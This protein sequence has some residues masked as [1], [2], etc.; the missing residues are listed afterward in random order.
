MDN[1]KKVIAITLCLVLAVGSFG[2]A[3][4]NT[5]KSVDYEGHWAQTTIQKWVDESKISGYPD[6]SF[7]PDASI[8]RAE[9]VKMVNGIIDYD[10][11]GNL[12]FS[13]VKTGDWYYDVISI[14]QEI[15][16]ITGYSETQ[17]GPNDNITREQAA[18]I[19]SRI[20]YLGENAEAAVKFGDNSNIST[21][22]LGSVGAASEVGFIK[23]YDNG[24]F[25]PLN[26]LTRAEAV[27]MLDNVL[28]NSKNQVIYKAGTELSNYVV[29]GDLIIAK[30]VGEGD[31][32]LNNVEVKG[33][34]YVYGGGENSLYFNN[35]KVARVVV[36]KDKVRLVFD[37]GSNIADIIVNSEAKL[38]NE[39]GETVGNVTINE[40]GTV[41][42]KGNFDD[43]TIN[44]GSTANLVGTFNNVLI[45]TEKKV[46]VEGTFKNVEVVAK[47][48]FVMKD[49]KITTLK[50]D[51]AVSVSG[52]GTIATLNA[53]VDGITYDSTVKVTKTV[54]APEVTKEPEKIT[55][56]ST[57]GS[58]SGSGSGSDPTY[59]LVIGVSYEP[60]TPALDSSFTPVNAYSS[61]AKISDYLASEVTGILGDTAYESIINNYLTKINSRL[62]DSSADGF[63]I[64]DTVVYTDAGWDKVIGYLDGTSITPS[65]LV[66]LKIKLMDNNIEINDMKAIVALY[67]SAKV[68]EDLTAVKANLTGYP[69]TTQTITYNGGAVTFK[70]NNVVKTNEQMANFILDNIAYSTKTVDEFFNAFGVT[71][72]DGTTITIETIYGGKTSTITLTR[73]E[74]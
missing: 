29:E 8:T 10:V 21:W 61:T 2:T 32:H 1:F 25:K 53:N 60:S 33:N 12:V 34:L 23:G 63:K 67:D 4:A 71:G 27:T 58:G 50:L 15:G 11:K 68:L 59:K 26:K 73:V 3:F 37:E 39:S 46:T 56:P 42:I 47:T 31:V 7:K 55:E 40:G 52:T 16:Y 9:F 17:F 14:A 57:P 30:T 43:V 51:A 6:G 72:A 36:D 44:E 74:Q 45:K 22:A 20:Q 28:V 24:S 65:E 54:V 66:N 19:L 41:T 13:D 69:F 49:A 5:S 64:G 18:A 35:L 62:N 70:I 48:D 38:E